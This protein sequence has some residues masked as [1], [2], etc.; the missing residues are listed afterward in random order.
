[1]TEAHEP[2][3]AIQAYRDALNSFNNTTGLNA[4]K[5]LFL[6]GL[7]LNILTFVLP[8]NEAQQG[9]LNIAN[10][11]IHSNEEDRFSWID[12]HYG[13]R[14]LLLTT[15]PHQGEIMAYLSAVFMGTPDINEAL[16]SWALSKDS[17]PYHWKL[18]FKIS[19]STQVAGCESEDSYLVP[20]AYIANLR[21]VEPVG[22]NS[23]MFL[24]FLMKL[25]S[26]FRGLLRR[27][28]PRAVW[29]LGYWF[30][31]MCRLPKI[32]WCTDRAKREYFGIC[33]WFQQSHVEERIQDAVW[34]LLVK[35]LF[36]VARFY[37]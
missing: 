27:R 35:D 24:S 20:L 25:D 21:E 22:K 11:C 2:W 14:Q 32:W 16:P 34:L 36:H 10:S 31:L 4:A 3:K 8:E 1:M 15:A 23:F 13:F 6:V 33:T 37:Y 30:G 26:H 29:I 17:I 7:L 19:S 12:I 28:D 9:L 18:A 5:R